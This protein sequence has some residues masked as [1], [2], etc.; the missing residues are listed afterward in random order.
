MNQLRVTLLTIFAFVAVASADTIPPNVIVVMTDDQ[1]YG[2][3]A[4]HG[5]PFLKTP[6]LDTLHAESTWLHRLPSQPDLF[7]NPLGDNER[8]A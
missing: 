3:L 7:T 6:L 8:S 5:H 1:G 2:D 4:C